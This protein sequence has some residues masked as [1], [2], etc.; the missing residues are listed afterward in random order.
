MAHL[1]DADSQSRSVQHYLVHAIAPETRHTYRT[2]VDHWRSYSESRGWCPDDPVTSLRAEEWLAGLADGGRHKASTIRTYKAALSTYHEERSTAPNPLKSDRIS[3]LLAGIKNSLAD[4]AALTQ[5]KPAKP[6]TPGVTMAMVRLLEAQFN[7]GSTREVMMLGAIA[8]ATAAALRP[9]ELLGTP[10]LR[11]ALATNQLCFFDSLDQPL[12]HI[13]HGGVVPDHCTV[14]L[15]ISKT[16]QG[17]KD[18]EIQIAAPVAVRAIWAWRLIRHPDSENGRHGAEL[19][20]MRSAESLKMSALLGFT[21]QSL[22][23]IGQGDLPLTGKCFR[24]GGTSTLAERGASDADL[25]KLGR[26]RTSMWT[27]YA[28]P[29]SQKKRDLSVRRAM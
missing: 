18:E 23:D 14:T 29:A 8:L 12:S 3:R 11:R 27:A 9:N 7:R 24:I 5:H 26:W 2:A 21:R 13:D 1:H 16:N 10:R 20:R 6:K 19:F 4:N 15:R 17:G 28:D 25:R 22:R